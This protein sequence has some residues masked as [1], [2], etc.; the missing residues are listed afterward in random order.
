RPGDVINEI[1]RVRI[2]SVSDYRNAI[3]KVK[4]N[5]LAR[6]SRGYVVIKGGG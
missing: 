1:N 2:E 5:V 3:A 6:T 4:G